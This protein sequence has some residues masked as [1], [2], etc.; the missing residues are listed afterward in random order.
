[1]Q[2]LYLYCIPRESPEFQPELQSFREYELIPLSYKK[3]TVALAEIYPKWSIKTLQ[4]Q[5]CHKLKN[6]K[7][8]RIWKE[9]VKRGGTLID[10][11]KYVEMQTFEHFQEAK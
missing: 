9:D 3:K 6:K 2:F 1:M 4:R 7:M 10:K 8:L 11:W 5:G